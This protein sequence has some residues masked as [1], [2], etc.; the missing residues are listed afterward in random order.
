MCVNIENDEL[1]LEIQ[2]VQKSN[3]ERYIL[4]VSSTAVPNRSEPTLQNENLLSNNKNGI[5]LAPPA[6]V[7]LLGQNT[8]KDYTYGYEQSNENLD[9]QNGPTLN[10]FSPTQKFS[11]SQYTKSRD[12]DVGSNNVSLYESD[13]SEQIRKK[14]LHLNFSTFS[15]SKDLKPEREVQSR[16][17]RS[18]TIICDNDPIKIIAATD[19]ASSTAD[20]LM[21]IT[22]LDHGNAKLGEIESSG[23]SSSGKQRKSKSSNNIMT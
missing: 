8:N 2:S 9:E 3:K 15:N 1:L 6:F 20:I 16:R 4:E 23:N 17:V 10:F 11:Y 14:K 5:Q 22:E 13:K 18:S 12:D 7:G 19:T 21:V